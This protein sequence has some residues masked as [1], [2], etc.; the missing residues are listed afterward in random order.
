M[1]EPT[2]QVDPEGEHRAFETLK[3]MAADRITV[4]V[5]HRLENTRVADSIIVM[6]EGR[7]TEQGRYEDLAAANGTFARLLA[8]SQDR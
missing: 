8:L 1:D 6:E 4:V 7:I 3:A 2:S 5:T